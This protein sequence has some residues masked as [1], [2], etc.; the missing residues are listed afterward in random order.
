VVGSAQLPYDRFANN[1]TDNMQYWCYYKQ[2]T[3]MR[4]QQDERIAAY[5]AAAANASSEWSSSE[6]ELSKERE[7]HLDTLKELRKAQEQ[8]RYINST[9]ACLLSVSRTLYS[10]LVQASALTGVIRYVLSSAR[11]GQQ[12][13]QCLQCL[14]VLS[15]RR[16]KC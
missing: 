12:Y 9:S 15:L 4:K 1:T 2:L 14:F 5:K 10:L 8:I 11:S 6:Y 13:T 16:M 3:A 7:S